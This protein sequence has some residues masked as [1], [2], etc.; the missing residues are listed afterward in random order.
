MENHQ[1]INYQR[2]LDDLIR[3]LDPNA[4]PPKL[5]LHACCAPCSSYVLE[6]LSQYFEITVF[7]YN[8]NIYP[9][10]EYAHRVSELQRLIDTMPMKNKVNLIERGYDPKEFY[11]AVRGLEDIPEGG[12]RCFACYRLRL[13][14]TAQLAL[15]LGAD[16]FTTTL[17]ISPYKNSAKLNEISEEL[18]E[19]YSLKALPADFKKKNGYKRSI[20]LSAEYGLYRQDYCGCVFSKRERF[21]DKT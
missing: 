3:G 4:A 2:K 17:S 6:Y 13:E 16:Y 5:L 12:E 21:G 15:E 8:P 14:R 7:Y 11:E 19:V 18:G 1:K 9:P 10:E 20:E